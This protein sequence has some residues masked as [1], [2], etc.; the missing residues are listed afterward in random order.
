MPS[1]RACRLSDCVS[2]SGRLALDL[3][4]AE[5]QK[6]RFGATTRPKRARSAEPGRITNAVRREV[7]A[8]DEL[9][10]TY[11]DGQ[12]KRCNAR[13]FLQHDHKKPRGLGGDSGADNVRTPSTIAS[14]PSVSTVAAISR[15]R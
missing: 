4:V 8:R 2:R 14:R 5:L 6:K 10:C 15:G 12:G 7:L 11:V 9:G 3:L 1:L 13:A